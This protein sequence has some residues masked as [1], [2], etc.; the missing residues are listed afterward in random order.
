M[1]TLYISKHGTCIKFQKWDRDEKRFIIY[2]S[3][4]WTPTHSVY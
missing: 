1:I 2:T 4:I 3:Y